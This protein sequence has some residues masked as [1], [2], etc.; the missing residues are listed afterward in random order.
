MKVVDRG[1]RPGRASS[2]RQ[3]TSKLG[4][5][6]AGA[7]EA[8]DVTGATDVRTEHGMRRS[9]FPVDATRAHG[10]WVRNC[11]ANRRKEL[12]GSPQSFHGRTE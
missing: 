2:G 4:K 6:Q 5:F 12:S 11:A 3:E 1:G 8:P 9:E 10:K 7:G